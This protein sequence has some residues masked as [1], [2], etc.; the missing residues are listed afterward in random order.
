MY[1]PVESK[2]L[3]VSKSLVELKSLVEYKSMI[4]IVSVLCGL[5]IKWVNFE[6]A[7][8]ILRPGLV[9]IKITQW[10]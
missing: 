2:S 1:P 4:V 5:E 3:V 7:T 10:S 9:G 6:I 8:E